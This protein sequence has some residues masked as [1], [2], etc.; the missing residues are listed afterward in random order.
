MD[1]SA[2]DTVNAILGS[3]SLPDYD[4]ND[5]VPID[6]SEDGVP[7]E[8]DDDDGV[9]IDDSDDGVPIDD[10]DDGVPIEDDSDD[11]VP[12]DDSDCVEESSGVTLDASDNPLDCSE[13]NGIPIDVEESV[14][15]VTPNQLNNKNEKL[16]AEHIDRTGMFINEWLGMLFNNQGLPKNHAEILAD[17]FKL[18]NSRVY[19]INY[20]QNHYRNAGKVTEME[21]PYFDQFVKIARLFLVAAT[22][23]NDY[24]VIGPFVNIMRW[25]KAVGDT[26]EYMFAYLVNIRVWHEDGFWDK[27]IS[28]IINHEVTHRNITI[29]PD[30]IYTLLKELAPNMLKTGVPTSDVNEFLIKYCKEYSIN[31]SLQQSLLDLV[32]GL[33]RPPERK[34]AQSIESQPSVPQ[35]DI[36]A[37]EKSSSKKKKKSKPVLSP[38]LKEQKD[39]GEALSSIIDPVA[40]STYSQDILFDLKDTLTGH[41]KHG[42]VTCVSFQYPKIVTGTATGNVLLYDIVAKN[43]SSYNFR[44]HKKQI[45]SIIVADDFMITAGK[46]GVS[47]FYFYLFYLN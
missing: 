23:E 36:I 20:L 26:E 39:D 25:F 28:A 5:G 13:D 12:I 4:D 11:G 29:S 32:E 45:N 3:L 33:R 17:L 18:Q 6:D 22:E 27:A 14:K 46:D 10:E 38:R 15:T 21:W 2:M 34:D 40:T 35:T 16:A 44:Y 31:E 7:I 42:P 43:Y 8:E 41:K 1:M 24:T 9:P 19:Y 30:V 47:I 37:E